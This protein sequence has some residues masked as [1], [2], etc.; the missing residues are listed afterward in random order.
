MEQVAEFKLDLGP[1]EIWRKNKSRMVQVSAN[2]G[3]MALGTVVDKIRER[4]KDL[5]FPK[6]YFYRFGGNYDKMVE[7]QRQLTFA[8]IL[9]L[10]LVFMVL[11]SLFESYLQPLI[12][13]AS[14][15][16][17]AIGIVAALTLTHKPV[18]IG[19]L[20]GV[21][22]LAGIV[23]NNAIILVDR[24][25]R[26]RREENKPTHQ[27]VISACEDR[28][29]PILMTSSTTVLGLLPMALDRSEAANLWSP[30]AIAVIGGLLSSTVM[31]LFIVPSIY[32]LFE[33]IKSGLKRKIQ[34]IH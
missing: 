7:N 25:N 9:T 32:L 24:I 29:R 20:I 11:A 4:L 6:D 19:V 23:V 13:M 22:M 8:L 10:I 27:A 26:F 18:G 1:S 2:T 28:L 14:V 16:L 31:T 17:A 30:L 33:D 5:E 34:K 15:P 12:I 3:G 21:I